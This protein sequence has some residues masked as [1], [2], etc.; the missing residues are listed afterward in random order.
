[1]EYNIDLRME[2]YEIAACAL[3]ESVTEKLPDEI[4]AVLADMDYILKVE[5]DINVIGLELLDTTCNKL[6]EIFTCTE[7]MRLALKETV[8][9]VLDFKLSLRKFR[10]LEEAI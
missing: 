8:N 6:I 7:R 5:E 1:M 4:F 10:V 3:D 2:I 9:A